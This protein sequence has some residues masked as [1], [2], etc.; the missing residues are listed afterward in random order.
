MSYI[1]DT[2]NGLH[3]VARPG[4]V[5]ALRRFP[6]C[7]ARES[8]SGINKRPTR[9]ASDHL[10]SSGLSAE[11]ILSRA[12]LVGFTWFPWTDEVRMDKSKGSLR[13]SSG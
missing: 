13:A 6:E 1:G 7:S 9:T 8:E 2:D 4:F 10:G 5:G 12:E 11:H 3:P